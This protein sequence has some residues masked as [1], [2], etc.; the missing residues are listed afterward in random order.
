MST[1]PGVIISWVVSA[2]AFIGGSFNRRNGMIVPAETSALGDSEC[3]D[4]FA[5]LPGT[6]TV[7]TEPIE[8]G[9]ENRAICAAVHTENS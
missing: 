3:A 6:A 5:R 7:R 9:N 1:R 8:D 4:M 2:R